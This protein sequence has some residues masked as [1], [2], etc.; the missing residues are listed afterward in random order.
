MKMSNMRVR[1]GETLLELGKQDPRVVVLE[2]D[3]GKS[4][5]TNAFK[6][7]YPER[8]FEMGIAEADMTA[9]AVGLSLTGKVA[10]TN[11]FA[12]FALGRAYDPVRQDVAY[13]GA[14]VKIVGSSAGFSDYGDGASHQSIDDIALAR[15]LPGMTVLVAG[16]GEE[17]A[18]MTRWAAAYDGPVYLRISRN[19]VPVIV[20]EDAD[21]LSPVVLKDGCDVAILSCGIM[22]A[23]A[24]AAAETLEKEGIC[25]RV[26]HI[27]C[28]KPLSDEAIREAVGDVKAVVTAEEHSVIGGLSAAVA[29]ALR[30]DARPLEAVAV[31]DQFG[32]SAQNPEVLLEAYG[33]TAENI[34]N[35]AKKVLK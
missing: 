4:T 22:S 25:A 16:D 2:A 8:Y 31:M 23:R 20:P 17:A 19:D 6:G 27:P 30:G 34:A 14:N 33:L 32:Q 9:F 28:L 12:V 13:P 11:S 15:V 10:F 24:L 7:Q 18:R 3:L 5:M 35:T 26:V 1:Y 21:V 29:W